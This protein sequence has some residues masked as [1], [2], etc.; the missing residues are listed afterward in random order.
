MTL[1]PERF[2][3]WYTI[4]WLVELAAYSIILTLCFAIA[5]KIVERQVHGVSWNWNNFSWWE[6]LLAMT[7]GFYF[8]WRL[9]WSEYRA[10]RWP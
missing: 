2:R 5:L 7:C 9:Q 3:D 6:V 8:A 10:G 4:R 1:V